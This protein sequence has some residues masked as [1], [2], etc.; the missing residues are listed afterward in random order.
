MTS[1]QGRHADARSW[2]RLSAHR[3]P[4]ERAAEAVGLREAVGLMQRCSPSGRWSSRPAASNCPAC[5]CGGHQR[6]CRTWT[7][8]TP[9]PPVPPASPS[10][11]CSRHPGLPFPLVFGSFTFVPPSPSSF[12]NGSFSPLRSQLQRCPCPAP[13]A[14]FPPRDCLSCSCILLLYSALL[15]REIISIICCF[16]DS[17]SPPSTPDAP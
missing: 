7:Q 10:S 12:S 8:L 17:F 5:A 1:L 9:P 2:C 4:V 14:S 6:L 13:E 3:R 15:S 11:V 16:V